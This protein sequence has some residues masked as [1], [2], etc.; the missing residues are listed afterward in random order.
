MPNVTL[1]KGNRYAMV[2]G[3]Y[4]HT[5]LHGVRVSDVPVAVAVELAKRKTHKGEALFKVEEMPTVLTDI[6][7]PPKAKPDKAIVQNVTGT[8][9]KTDNHTQMRFDQW[10]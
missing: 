8:H 4:H 10:H 9:P 3:R 2:M 5:F 1:L 6:K 7:H